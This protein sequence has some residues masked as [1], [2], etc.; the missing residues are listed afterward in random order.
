M[1]GA[2]R[3]GAVV[4]AGFRKDDA[5]PG[6]QSKRTRYVNFGSC[7]QLVFSF[8]VPGWGMSGAFQASRRLGA[9]VDVDLRKE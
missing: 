6:A 9:I 5:C 1:S 3:R 4:G 7:R 2:L 8:G